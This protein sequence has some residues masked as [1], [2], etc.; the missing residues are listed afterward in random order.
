MDREVVLEPLIASMRKG[1]PLSRAEILEA[2][3]GWQALPFMVGSEHVGSAI[4]NGNEIHFALV[5]GQRPAGCVR[6][7]IQAFIQPL[8]TLNGFLT[9]RVRLGQAKEKRFV[10]RVGFR[11]TWNDDQFQYYL[12]GRLPF[13]RS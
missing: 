2:V 4:V 11:P 3:Q 5:P 13:A 8:L 12:L 9:T 7:A 6:G 1:T 10:E